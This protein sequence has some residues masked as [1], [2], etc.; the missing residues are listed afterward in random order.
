MKTPSSASRREERIQ[1]RRLGGKEDPP[2]ASIPA[3]S[4]KTLGEGPFERNSLDQR[5]LVPCQV[6]RRGYRRITPSH[7]W[8]RHRVRMA[9]Y[10]DR[11][12][13]AALLSDEMIREMSEYISASW[14][15]RGRHWTPERVRQAIRDDRDRGQLLNADSVHGRNRR[16][17]GAAWRH[18]G[19]W[20][21]ALRLSGLDPGLVRRRGRWTQETVFRALWKAD[22]EGTLRRKGALMHAAAR[23]FGSWRTA[24]QAAGLPVRRAP[25]VAWTRA[26]VRS[27]IRDR[28]R[29][30]L[31]LRA[32]EVH[33]QAP[34]LWRATRRL[35]REPWPDLIAA[36]SLPYSGRRIWDSSR[37]L[38]A[39]RRV[40]RDHPLLRK[41]DIRQSCPGLLSA[42][43]RWFGSWGKAVRAAKSRAPAGV[44]RTR[45]RRSRLALLPYRPP[46]TKR[47]IEELSPVRLRAN[48]T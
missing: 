36:L 6:C 2:L 40:K 8:F 27:A 45:V 21:Q 42:G 31:S 13:K 43:V 10:R 3:Q 19:S 28:A 44:S 47:R 48:R 23:V 41:H 24:L 5:F 18:L 32:S 30:G 15:A 46:R 22:T 35:F 20:D 26:L 17:Y 39:I 14:E 38:R 33:D 1:D 7:L 11:F 29:L 16:L 12:P 4:Q 37:V 25:R 9:A 34:G